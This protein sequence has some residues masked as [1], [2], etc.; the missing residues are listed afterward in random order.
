MSSRAGMYRSVNAGPAI[1]CGVTGR[2]PSRK[3]FRSPRWS[4]CVVIV[5]VLTDFRSSRVRSMA[6]TG[7]RV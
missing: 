4:S 2:M 6:M 5:A 1:R 3:T 7:L